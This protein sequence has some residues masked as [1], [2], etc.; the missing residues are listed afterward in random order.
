MMMPTAR[1][2]RL[3]ASRVVDREGECRFTLRRQFGA[4]QLFDGPRK[5]MFSSCSPISALVA[6]VK[7][8]DGQ[9][10]PPW[11]GP[12]GSAMPQTAYPSPGSPSSRSRSGSRAP[13]L[14]SAAACRRR[15]TMERPRDLGAF[16]SSSGDHGLR[17]VDPGQLV[18]YHVRDMLARTRSWPAAVST[19][20]L[21]GIGVGQDHVEGGE[22]VGG[23]D[24]QLVVASTA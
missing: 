3:A 10:L 16:S 6:G 20:P 2:R 8:G 15:T 7:I 9:L 23:D 14:R 17:P 5:L 12:C 11:A 1:G 18:R 22:A 19:A 21:P 4:E 13:R 24:Q